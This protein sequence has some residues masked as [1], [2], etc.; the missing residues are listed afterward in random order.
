MEVAD[1]I[2]IL[3]SDGN[4]SKQLYPV[5]GHGSCLW[6]A[7]WEWAIIAVQRETLPAARTMIIPR[8]ES[9]SI[10]RPMTAY[11]QRER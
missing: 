3:W 11:P 8:E 1:S 6:T 4:N 10:E 7:T 5:F 2:W 9:P